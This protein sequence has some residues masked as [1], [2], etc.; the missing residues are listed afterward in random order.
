MSCPISASYPTTQLS[1]QLKTT[2]CKALFT[3]APLIDTALESAAAAGIPRKHVYVL[4]VP[5][6]AKNGTTAPADL[7]T[8][9]DLI[10]DGHSRAQLPELLWQEGQGAR[11]TAFLCSSSGTSGLP[12]NINDLLALQRLWLIPR[13]C[14]KM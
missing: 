5:E 12:V 2:R 9:D 8:V 1:H 10:E 11:Q 3:S 6:Q 13:S 14:R 4:E 7:K